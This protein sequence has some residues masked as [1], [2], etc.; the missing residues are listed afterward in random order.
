MPNAVP[1]TQREER[2]QK[3]MVIGFQFLNFSF[4]YLKK[5]QKSELLHTK[6][7]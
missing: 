7:L 2:E 5:L 4:E 6:C 1:V 3:G